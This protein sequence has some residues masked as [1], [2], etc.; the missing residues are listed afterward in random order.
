M[1]DK[2]C[3]IDWILNQKSVS[4][5]SHFLKE[6]GTEASEQVSK[7]LVSHFPEGIGN[8]TPNFTLSGYKPCHKKAF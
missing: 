3:R 4:F 6:N 2:S 7:L 1:S 5:Q 8:D